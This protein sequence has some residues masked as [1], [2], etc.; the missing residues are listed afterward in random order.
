MQVLHLT[1]VGKDTLACYLSAAW[2]NVGAGNT[3]INVLSG[4]TV[5]NI[6]NSY[7]GTGHY[8]PTAGVQW[9]DGQIVTWLKTTMPR[10]S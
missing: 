10:V 8:S 3:P 9:D 6:W 1:G 7:V 4:G 2:L 5:K